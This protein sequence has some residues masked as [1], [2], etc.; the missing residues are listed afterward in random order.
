VEPLYAARAVI[1]RTPLPAAGN[2]S[3]VDVIPTSG[4]VAQ[5][6]RAQL[7]FPV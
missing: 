7:S 3:R 1:R 6:N 2:A 5:M 4:R